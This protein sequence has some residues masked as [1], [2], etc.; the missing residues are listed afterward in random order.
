MLHNLWRVRGREGELVDV[1]RDAPPGAK[2]ELT[3]PLSQT[4]ASKQIQNYIASVSGTGGN[5]GIETVKKVFL[6]SN[7]PT[8]ITRSS[9]T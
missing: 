1:L 3:Y 2:D 4:E 9:A 8:L 6:D 5:E 7:P